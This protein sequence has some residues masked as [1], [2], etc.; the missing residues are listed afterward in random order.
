M[1]IKKPDTSKKNDSYVNDIGFR[2]I[3]V[4]AF[5]IIIPLV[6]GMINAYNFSNWQVKLSFLYNIGISAVI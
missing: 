6:T 3:L 4:P 1:N 2:L 5:G